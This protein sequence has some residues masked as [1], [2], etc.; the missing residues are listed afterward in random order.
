MRQIVVGL[1]LLFCVALLGCATEERNP[2]EGSW[3]IAAGHQ[4]TAD[5][6]FSYTEGNPSTIKMFVGNQVGWF[7]R[8]AYRGGDTLTYY[9]WGTYVVEGSNYTEYIKYHTEKSL[10]GKAIPLEVEIRNDTLIQKGPRKIGEYAD[11]KWEMYEV[12]V[13]LK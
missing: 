10:V 12:W 9:G 13:R 1:T 7:G 6:A 8:W 3:R 5:T 11:G 2:L 4:K